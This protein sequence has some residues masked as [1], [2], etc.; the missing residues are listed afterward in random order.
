[1]NIQQLNT[2]DTGFWSKL[3]GLLAWDSVSDQTIFDTVN[4]ILADVKNRGDAA[5]VEYTNKFDAVDVA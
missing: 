3:D 5:V 2:S 1:M 4:G